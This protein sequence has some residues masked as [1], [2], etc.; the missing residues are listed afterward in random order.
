LV[1]LV[2]FFARLVHGKTLEIAGVA[3]SRLILHGKRGTLIGDSRGMR[4]TPRGQENFAPPQWQ[5]VP[6]AENLDV[7][8]VTDDFGTYIRE[9]IEPGISGRNNLTVMKLCDAAV[10]ACGGQPVEIP[11]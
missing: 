6:L 2:H 8:G 3:D 7:Q 4:F 10:Q 1:I 5:E 9:D 11:T